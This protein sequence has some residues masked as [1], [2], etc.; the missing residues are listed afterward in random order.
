MP[1]I[2]I[3]TAN[4]DADPIGQPQ[5][6]MFAEMRAALGITKATDILDHIYSLPDPESDLAME[7]IR[8]IERR[9]MTVQQP[10]E[11]LLPLMDYLKGKDMKKA[12]CTR[13][14]KSVSRSKLTDRGAR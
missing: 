4:A 14:F 12:I 7:K 13:N 1:K 8:A 11:G 5:N 6:Y 2:K 9:A 10:Q 3:P